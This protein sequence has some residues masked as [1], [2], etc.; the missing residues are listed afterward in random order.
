MVYLKGRWRDIY[1]I[2][3][4]LTSHERA[5]IDYRPEANE[6]FWRNTGTFKYHHGHSLPDFNINVF[7]VATK[8]IA[9]VMNGE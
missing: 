3:K 6:G 7:M 4:F 1:L 9:I 5:G 2:S 8:V